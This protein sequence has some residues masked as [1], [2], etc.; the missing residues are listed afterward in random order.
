MYS[1]EF[2]KTAEKQ[3]F[4]LERKAQTRIISVLDR[5]RIRPYS[6]VKKLVGSSYFRLRVGEY[7]VILDIRENR[8]VIFV[9]E[10]GHRSDIY[11]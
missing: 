1:I 7:R 5:I 11:K 10:A 6:H 3:F 4:K 8:L 2:S 9:I